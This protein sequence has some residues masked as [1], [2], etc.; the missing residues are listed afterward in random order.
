MLSSS[1]EGLTFTIE[2]GKKGRMFVHFFAVLHLL[3]GVVPG[4]EDVQLGSVNGKDA[5]QLG[6]HVDVEITVVA[7]QDPKIS[8]FQQ[9]RL[10]IDFSSSR[11]V[12]STRQTAGQR[13]R[14]KGKE[15]SVSK[16]PSR[17]KGP[18]LP[19]VCLKARTKLLGGILN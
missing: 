11:H 13:E 7:L 8:I 3:V 14:N 17:F 10:L 6:Q 18:I 19:P 16:L 5:L 12:Q 9:E 1:L 4:Q 15:E 2:K